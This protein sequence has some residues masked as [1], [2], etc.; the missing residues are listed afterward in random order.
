MIVYKTT[1]LLLKN[2]LKGRAEHHFGKFAG[3]GTFSVWQ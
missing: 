2:K 1:I 3:L